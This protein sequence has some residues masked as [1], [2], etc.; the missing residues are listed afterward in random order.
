MNMHTTLFASAVIATLASTT[1][2]Q[3]W[4]Q[5][6]PATSPIAGRD[7][8]MAF[9]F[10]SGSVLMYG[11]LLTGNAINS[12][13]W[14][15]DG[16]NWTQLSPATT[17]PT[18]WGHRCVQDTRRNRIVAFG[19]RS[20]TITANANDTWEWNGLDWQRVVTAHAPSARAF[21]SMVFDERRGKVVLYGAQSGFPNG[22]QT[23]EYDG[24]DW[25]QVVTTTTPPG[26]ETPAMAYDKARG[27]TVMF[28]GWNGLSPGVM[29]NTTWEYDGV[30][31]RQVATATSPTARYR[32]SCVYDDARGRTVMY[33]GYGSGAL[34][35]TWEYDGNDWTQVPASG[36]TRSTECAMAYDIFRQQSYLFGGSGP[37]G[38]SAETWIY[39][40]P[41]TA[42]FAPFGHGC[43]GGNGTPTLA[44]NPPVLGQ[45]FVLNIGSLG[46]QVVGGLLLQGFTS[47][48]FAGTFLPLDLSPFGMSGCGLEVAPATNSFLLASNGNASF[49]FVVPNQPSLIGLHYFT[50][51]MGLDFA[52]PNSSVSMSNAGH[53]L[54]GL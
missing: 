54:L 8:G 22:D 36:T 7:Q 24:V 51:F 29:Y 25:A 47:T 19:G 34:T 21:Y 30:D 38:I 52:A 32:A 27:V 42:L 53:A 31:W 44:A 18:R 46:N 20:P 41:R 48:S 3:T 11:G 16:S 28:G 15:F 9:D 13:T 33:G 2:A 45:P 4:T 14:L 1:L 10:S 35:D 50:Q 23:W 37:S 26:L 49:G 43:P 5:V 40:G 17:P 39:T 12:D 6:T